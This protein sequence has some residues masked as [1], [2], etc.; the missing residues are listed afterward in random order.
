MIEAPMGEIVA[1]QAVGDP[2]GWVS[3]NCTH[4][5]GATSSVSM[6]CTA[7]TTVAAGSRHP[8]D[9]TQALHLQLLIA[10]IEAQ[11]GG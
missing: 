1:V 3:V 7:A 6:C 5:S 4:E 8:A 10:D 2:L 11:L 9:A